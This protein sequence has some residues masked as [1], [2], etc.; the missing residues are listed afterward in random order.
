MSA[1]PF[2]WRFPWNL[3]FLPRTPESF[4]HS[5]M[6]LSVYSA[7]LSTLFLALSIALFIAWFLQIGAI[8]ASVGILM[9]LFSIALL[10][11]IKWLQKF[12][13]AELTCIAIVLLSLIVGTDVCLF[14]L[15]CKQTVLSVLVVSGTTIFWA[16]ISLRYLVQARDFADRAHD[17]V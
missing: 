8:V 12:G 2:V 11:R 6:D 9:L 14:L 15:L 13:R 16:I 3:I 4:R 5:V 17:V 10:I 1:G 7:A